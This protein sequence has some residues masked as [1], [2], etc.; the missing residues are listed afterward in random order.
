MLDRDHRRH[1]LARQLVAH[2]QQFV[3]NEGGYDVLYLHTNPRVPGAEAFWRSLP[4][5]LVYDDRT[6][7]GKIVKG[8]RM[9]T[10]HFELL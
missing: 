9:E 5:R 6:E 8:L 7:G 1:G 2:V 10:L 3:A 4:T